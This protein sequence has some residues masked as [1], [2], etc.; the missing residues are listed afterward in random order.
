V[1][2]DPTAQ[3]RLH[4]RDHERWEHRRFGGGLELGEERLPV[5]LDRPVKHGVLGPVALV[6]AWSTGV[7]RVSAGVGLGA[8]RRS[9]G[10][11]RVGPGH[12]LPA[13]AR[14]PIRFVVTRSGGY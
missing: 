7:A 3:E 10:V 11:G 9:M 1:R 6:G 14:W 12:D 8:L 4:F 13:S 2:Q 5:G